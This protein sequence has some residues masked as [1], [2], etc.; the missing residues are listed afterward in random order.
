M[1]R[2]WT[3]AARAI[4]QRRSA[5]AS[6]TSPW[7]RG[8]I[9]LLTGAALA[10]FAA[11]CVVLFTMGT[12]YHIYFNRENLP[13]LETFAR[14]EFPTIGHVTDRYGQPLVEFARE[15]RQITQFAEIPPIVRDAI[16]ATEDKHFFS[17]N[18]VDYL[19]LPRVV[20]KVRIGAWGTR[21]GHRGHD[22]YWTPAQPG[23]HCSNLNSATQGPVRP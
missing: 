1:T 19:S 2:V 17:H 8:V 18:G 13:D 21:A 20:G 22:T 12:L 6:G 3:A 9:A 14:F 10:V 4:A 16:L 11:L 23:S 7:T 15:Y 5:I